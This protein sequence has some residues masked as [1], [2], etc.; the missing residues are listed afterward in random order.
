MMS[1][2]MSTYHPEILSIF[3]FFTNYLS[4]TLSRESNEKHRCCEK[5]PSSVFF[6][7]IL[8]QNYFKLNYYYLC[9]NVK[10]KK[11]KMK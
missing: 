5:I 10:E 9:L 4:T 6:E 8:C 3:S 7:S 11:K 1:T 2:D